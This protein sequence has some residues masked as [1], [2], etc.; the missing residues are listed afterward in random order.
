M[1]NS[2]K[3][4]YNISN[5]AHFKKTYFLKNSANLEEK[6][7]SG[8]N[9]HIITNK[10][11]TKTNYHDCPYYLGVLNANAFKTVCQKIGNC[12][13]PQGPNRKKEDKKP[14]FFNKKY[15]GGRR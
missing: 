15:T 8:K 5:L 13:F 10:V 4:R 1:A 9:N 12:L 3:L 11:V 2:K 7:M 14:S 6:V